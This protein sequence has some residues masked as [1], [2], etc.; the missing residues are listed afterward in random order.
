MFGTYLRR[1]LVGRRKQTVIIAIG[2]ALAIALVIL[3][4]SFSAGVKNAQA[5]VLESVYGVG[6]DITV[7][8]TPEAPS[9]EPG[10]GG[11]AGRFDFG[12]D[13]GTTTDDGSTA[14]SQSRLAA[15]RG[16][17]T[18]DAAAL[19][20]VLTVNNVAAASATLALTNTT[21]DG[22]LPDFSEV[23]SGGA[24]GDGAAPASG[25]ADGAGGSSFD[26]NSFTVLG[27][28]PSGDSVGPLSSVTLADGR[29]LDADDAEST[30]A[31]LDSSYATSAELAVGDTLNI[32]GTDFEVVG[33]VTSTSA[34]ATTA[35]NVYIPLGVAQSVAGLEGMVSTISVQAASSTAIAQVK[36]DIEAALPDATVSSQEDLASSV[37]GSLASASTLIS[38]LGTWLSLA[39][40]VAAF[41]LA[42]L[43]TISGVTRRTREFGT[44]KAIGWSN[45]RIIGQVAGESTV[46]A[47]IGGVIGVVVGLG[48]ILIINAA[49][50]TLGASATSSTGPGGVGSPGGAGPGGGFGGA[51]AAVA[52]T[53]DVV[54]NAP[55]TATVI[56]IAAGIALIGGLLAGAFGGWRAARLRPAEALRSVS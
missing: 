32:G 56:A 46:Q 43:F 25:G 47:L 34:D 6:T 20:S 11:G 55:I 19:D 31:I 42:I 45:R 13:D 23:R 52:Q 1:E 2:M 15:E 10:G 29:G 16:T 35:S 37:S 26:V 22:E 27:L 49:G 53:T 14:V 54:L 48:A 9:G 4:Q 17:E 41:A 8:Q 24:P 44:L 30:V 5:S 28:D 38:Q 50:I 40:L 51:A 12:A 7:S 36:S 33:T 3:V 21:F 39:V 18:F